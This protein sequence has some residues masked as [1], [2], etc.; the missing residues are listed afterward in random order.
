MGTEILI[1]I[2]TAV[3][4]STPAKTI[5][6]SC[7]NFAPAC[8]FKYFPSIPCKMTDDPTKLLKILEG[9]TSRSISC[10]FK[11]KSYF[12]LTINKHQKLIE[13]IHKV[14]KKYNIPPVLFAAIMIKESSLRLNSVNTNTNGSTDWGIAQVN[15]INV[16]EYELNTKK[17]LTD[18]EYSM[19]AGA[20]VLAW[21]KKTYEGREPNDWWVRYNCGTKKGT[22]RRTCEAYKMSVVTIIAKSKLKLLNF[23][24]STGGPNGQK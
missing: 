10:E 1:M 9:D 4:L 18:L 16:N 19:A 7:H 5:K 14:S 11:F 12:D 24:A 2:L 17:L 3:L 23:T 8:L 22:N 13:T 15:D 20:K 21:F 6:L